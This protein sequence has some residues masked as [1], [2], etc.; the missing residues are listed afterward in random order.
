M[1]W[2]TLSAGKNP[3]NLYCVW[4]ANN[5][6]PLCVLFAGFQPAHLLCGMAVVRQAKMRIHQGGD[7][8]KKQISSGSPIQQDSI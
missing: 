2:S 3:S 4:R 7:R 6:S 8:V 5:K 1:P